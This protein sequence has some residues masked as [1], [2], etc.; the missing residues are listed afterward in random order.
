M[1]VGILGRLAPLGRG[2]PRKESAAIGVGQPPWMPESASEI[3]RRRAQLLKLWRNLMALP[4]VSKLPDD[5]RRAIVRLIVV[6]LDTWTTTK[7]AQWCWYPVSGNG[8]L[9]IAAEAAGEGVFRPK[10]KPML[11]R[12]PNVADVRFLLA[13][14]DA[15]EANTGKRQLWRLRQVERMNRRRGTFSSVLRKP[16]P[17]LIAGAAWKSCG[18]NVPNTQW[19]GLIDNARKAGKPRFKHKT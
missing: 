18:H 15:W 13:C 8:A 10:R 16:V 6:A 2:R 1:R 12:K 11:G 4:P 5:K 17:I 14:A 3:V 9:G 7:G 19:P